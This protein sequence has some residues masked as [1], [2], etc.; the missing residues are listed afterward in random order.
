MPEWTA[1]QRQAIRHDQGSL[2]VSAAAGSGKTSVLAER[3]VHL[4]CDAHPRCG[5]DE[6]LVVTFTEAAAA[7]MKAR[8][9]E[10]LQARLTRTDDR[11]VARQVALIEHARIGTLHSFCAW[12][13]RRN[14]AQAGLDPDFRVLDEGEA[15][16][17][18][19]ETALA[20][21]R[22]WFDR[23]DN[24]GFRQLFDLLGNS[25]DAVAEMI[26]RGHALLGSLAD[27]AGW[28]R[29]SVSA[30]EE[31]VQKPL[32]DSTL[33][34]QYLQLVEQ[35]I[36]DTERDCQAAGTALA[37]M[38]GFEGY[39]RYV[40]ALAGNAEQ[41]RTRLASEG[42]DAARQAFRD[43][44]T[45][46]LPTVR[47]TVAGKEA[48]MALVDAARAPFDR[49]KGSLAAL[50]RFDAEQLRQG[51]AST[52]PAA[53]AY[54]GLLEA[55]DQRYRKEKDALLALDFADLEHYALDLLGQRTEAGLRPTAVARDLHQ[56]FRHVLV[57]EYQDINEVQDAILRLVSRECL[58]GETPAPA[59]LFCVGDVKQSIY[60][61]RLAEPRQFLQRRQH[62]REHPEAGAVIDLQ[63]NFRSRGPLLEAVNAVFERLMTAE[64]VDIDYDQSQRL[65]PGAVFPP[66]AQRC[67]P[68]APV[69]LHCLP[70]A[71]AAE[72]TESDAGD[73]D[74]SGLAD[75]E[76]AEREALLAGQ[77]IRR[78]MGLEAGHERMCVLDRG[79]AQPRPIEYRDI[80]VLLRSV[81]RYTTHYANVLQQMGIPVYCAEGTG[82]FESTE[83]Q[84]VL[85][86]LR[87]LDNPRQDIPLAAFLR[88][89][90]AGLPD[91]EESLA[92]IRCAGG[93]D[94]NPPPFH[95][96]AVR[97]AAEKNDALA[98]HLRRVLEQLAAWRDL[99][100]Q[101]PLADVIW[102]I[103]EQTGYLEYC[104]GLPGGQ[105]RCANLV[106][107]HERARQF[108]GFLQQS[109]YRFVKFLDELDRHIEA[110]QAPQLSAA[111]NVVRIMSIHKAKGLEFPVVIVPQ[112]G[113][114]F[115]TQDCGNAVL[116]ERRAGLG[117]RAIDSGKRV[118]YPS[119]AWTLV[120]HHLL[121]QAK[122]EEMRVMYVAMTRAR[123]HLILIGSIKE[124]QIQTWSNRW[125]EHDGP[126]PA[127][128]VL[129]ANSMADWIGPVAAAASRLPAPPLKLVWHD[130][131]EVTAWINN[132]EPRVAR[133]AVDSTIAA[134][135]PP[136]RPMPPD[137]T[138]EKVI[139]RLTG[140]YP[141]ADLC[142]LEA[143]KSVTA[144]TEQW[145][146]AP[147]PAGAHSSG[148]M[149]LRPP[150]CAGETV[151]L[152][153]VDRG[154]AFHQFLEHLDF[155]RPLTREDLAGQLRMLVRR[156]LMTPEQ[157][158]AICFDD[159]E[160]FFATDLGRALCRNAAGLLRELPIYYAMAPDRFGHTASSDPKDQ[161]M[162]RGRIDLLVPE[163]G[164]YAIVDYKTDRVNAD[165]AERRAELYRGQMSL[166]R[167]AVERILRRPVHAA[168]LVFLSAR[169]IVTL[170][171]QNA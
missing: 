90:L 92:L 107:L 86:L 122:A 103:Y 33:G 48:A 19:R 111:D 51:L 77:L 55:F 105:Q 131:Q 140:R 116:A 170:R 104:S 56:Q 69:E 44:E 114:K 161:V 29:R 35:S 115:N 25:E 113:K 98:E 14:F 49:E 158:E 167:E 94:D 24:D 46:R 133:A 138:A 129:R 146:A 162:M 40:V 127:A 87:L 4:V 144:W 52:L 85:S 125:A 1:E 143:A 79:S 123:E 26:I 5:I 9:T 88:S 96:A 37:R 3:C 89:P 159:I 171:W 57:D 139:S 59:N 11:Y 168:H 36:A 132:F 84:D 22:E 76:L 145:A 72:Q 136:P 68:G 80:V 155:S 110:P 152:A 45:G 157:A 10:A 17:L 93:T 30:I 163:N 148:A 106:A 99:A 119:L 50:L 28:L 78:M 75:M 95:E 109:L 2:L 70:Q 124:A 71:V 130:A 142:E 74:S 66:G 65:N 12:L 164:G 134:L 18:R 117:L 54:A 153:G 8:I 62:F 160:W 13:V 61:F 58:S 21:V 47:N 120:R 63:Q 41:L 118:H 34:R 7:E 6:L 73:D 121:R 20:I 102:S 39:A 27:G 166:Y 38:R 91:P 67:F 82:Y 165:D 81:R 126:L 32:R 64:A 154:T 135:E 42:Y 169:R 31:A 100:R 60:A 53:R 43:L 101:R 83:I 156:R 150:R 128:H 137:E 16:L 108:G 97:Y 141:F 23:R 149:P 112:M 15:A 151:P 147:G